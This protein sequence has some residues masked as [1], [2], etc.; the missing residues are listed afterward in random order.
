MV[1]LNVG[2]IW[3]I[4]PYSPYMNQHF[5]WMS[6]HIRTTWLSAPEDGN[7]HNYH[8]ENLK[9]YIVCRIHWT[10]EVW[11]I[12]VNCCVKEL[13]AWFMFYHV[14]IFT[15]K[16]KFGMYV[17][18]NFCMWYTYFNRLI[19]QGW[20]QCGIIPYHIMVLWWCLKCEKN[21]FSRKLQELFL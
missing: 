1:G 5:G 17:C 18:E 2:V 3:D 8:C 16:R 13:E 10:Q 4:A 15:I 7:I 20:I 11:R 9:P 19:F 21:S 6:G 12:N 14:G